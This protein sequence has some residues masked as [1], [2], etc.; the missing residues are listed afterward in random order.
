MPSNAVFQDVEAPRDALTDHAAATALRQKLWRSG[1]SPIPCDGKRPAPKAWEQKVETN[2]EEIALWEKVYR[3]ANNTGILTRLTP[4]I[5]IDI[6]DEAAAEAVEA[7]ARE[8]FEESGY[9]LVRI[10]KA[11]K[12]AVLLR[13]DMPFPKITRN[14]TAPNGGTHKIELL[15]DGQQIVVFGEHPETKQPYIWHGGEP[16]TIPLEE[17]PYVSRD[18]AVRFVDDAVELLM[19]EHGY[20]VGNNRPAATNG[21][22]QGGQADWSW[23]IGNLWNGRELHDSS[24]VLASKLIT[25]GM[26]DGAAVNMLRGLYES[27]GMP[28]DDRWQERYEDIP[29]AVASARRRFGADAVQ[30]RSDKAKPHTEK[31]AVEQD[32]RGDAPRQFE[33]DPVDLWGNFEPPTLPRGLLPEL[34]EK[35]AFTQAETMGVDP[36][37]VAMAALADPCSQ[38]FPISITIEPSSASR[39]AKRPASDSSQ[40]R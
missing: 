18:D 25:S 15:C 37:G 38:A 23:L 8:R 17:L 30:A 34:I 11:P 1:Y 20:T 39:S 35:Y 7:L 26:S 5:D 13:T 29:R 27:S 24:V 36:G 6:T 40:A 12:R 31:L 22:R 9:I 21:E 4:A 16:G 10:G 33:S 2:P 32:Q 3:F 19:R 14:L 28:R